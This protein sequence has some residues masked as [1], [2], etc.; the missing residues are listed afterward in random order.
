MSVKQTDGGE[1]LDAV[2]AAPAMRTVEVK[3]EIP[4]L[5]PLHPRAKKAVTTIKSASKPKKYTAAICIIALAAFGGYQL[6][7]NNLS[8][9]FV[10]GDASASSR[11]T[12]G[13]PEYKTILPANKTIEQL[14]GW[15]RI[16]PPGGNPVFAYV[17]RIGNATLSVSQQPLPDTLRGD[18]AAKVAELAQGFKATEKFSAGGTTVHIGTSADGPQSIIFDK[19]NLLIL[20]KSSARLENNL[21]A[22]YVS[23]L[24]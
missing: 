5:P 21:W 2:A 1:R 22:E 14:G 4:N 8:R 6:F 11:L 12:K 13:N 18:T 19:S 9:S 7:T 20:I 23:S 24:R 15:T 16:S 17:D 10:G 3:I